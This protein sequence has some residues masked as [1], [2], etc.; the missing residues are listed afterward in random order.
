MRGIFTCFFVLSP[1]KAGR[2]SYSYSKI[3]NADYEN[4]YEYEYEYEYELNINF[5]TKMS[6]QRHKSLFTIHG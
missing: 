1:A 3:F 5:Y 2:Y 6:R 4:D